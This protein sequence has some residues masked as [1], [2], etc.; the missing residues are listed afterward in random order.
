MSA[1]V[2]VPHT[3]RCG[4]NGVVT[5]R[6]AP[7]A[8]L[9]FASSFRCTACGEA[10]E[11][12]GDAIPSELRDA[13]YAA[14]GKSGLR[15]VGLG[16]DR[17]P[18]LLALRDVLHVTTAR[19]LEL[20]KTAAYVAEGTRTSVGVLGLPIE[21]KRAGLGSVRGWKKDKAPKLRPSNTLKFQ[22]DAI[23]EVIA[24][25]EKLAP[26]GWSIGRA[27]A[28]RSRSLFPEESPRLPRRAD[29]P[30]DRARLTPQQ[31]KR[32]DL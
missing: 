29:V 15:V 24:A 32:L 6:H 4:C 5:H 22:T 12:D 1:T 30:I 18:A 17:T 7:R 11:S 25:F 13:F 21:I 31:K 8:G 28:H 27:T 19:A 10:W 23:E 3:C 14:H 9:C 26:S 2:T 16:P 20:A